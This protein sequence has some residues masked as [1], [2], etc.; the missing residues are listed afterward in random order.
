MTTLGE[1]NET[2]M[3]IL[4]STA[5]RI[6]IRSRKK[7]GELWDSVTG[8]KIADLSGERSCEQCG[9]S[10]DGSFVFA[11][12]SDGPGQLFDARDGHPIA[13]GRIDPGAR[14][15]GYNSSSDGRR[16]I[17]RTIYNKLTLWNLENGTAITDVGVSD[18]E[19]YAFSPSGQQFILRSTNSSGE[20][21]ASNDGRP[22][23]TFGA[24]E[25]ATYK[26]SKSGDRLVTTTLALAASLW[27]S[28]TGHKIVDLAE[29]G[30]AD[31]ISLSDDGSR[32]S[33]GSDEKLGAFWDSERGIKLAD[34]R[35]SAEDSG[36][37]G[38]SKDGTRFVTS[39]GDNF[40]AL[41]DAKTGHY[42]ANLGGEGAVYDAEVSTDGDRV[43]TQSTSGT[44]AVWDSRNLP[45]ASSKRDL[46]THVCAVNYDSIKPFPPEIRISNQQIA[47][48]EVAVSFY[49]KGRPWHPCDWRGLLSLEGWAQML[50]FWAVKIGLPWDYRCGE[51]R[52]FAP[53]EETG[54]K[55]CES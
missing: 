12:R 6:V 50:R 8:G 3:F 4:F 21:R 33:V 24:G 31:H 52:A 46:T 30:V 23:T 18:G 45:K 2:V 25:F 48:V 37:G 11:I 5:A 40:G 44:M 17:T 29:P 53:I 19:N 14:I 15:A 39:G 22:L 32:L 43:A 54:A 35:R 10:G 42:L 9:F 20:M 7:A 38:F 41:W 28:A 47:N 13:S 51:R 34:Y 27:D 36:G 49:L 26:F 16:L 55:S 1:P